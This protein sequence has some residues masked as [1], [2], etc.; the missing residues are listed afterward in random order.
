MNSDT[1]ETGWG[2][3]QLLHINVKELLVVHK[4]VLKWKSK[5]KGKRVLLQMD[6]M[7]MLVYINKMMGRI[8]CLAWLAHEI[9]KVLRDLKTEMKAVYIQSKRNEVADAL[10]HQ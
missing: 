8:P 5:L 7:V 10:F 6:N 3:E 9:H 1:M 4:A 2:A